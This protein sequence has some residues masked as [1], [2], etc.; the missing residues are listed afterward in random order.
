MP[1]EYLAPFAVDIAASSCLTE[2][3]RGT[4]GVPDVRDVSASLF[5]RCLQYRCTA[6][7]ASGDVPLAYDLQI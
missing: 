5:G 4:D 1:Q 7:T 3:I 6:V 2:Y